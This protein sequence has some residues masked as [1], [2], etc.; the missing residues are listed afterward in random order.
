MFSVKNI[1]PITHIEHRHAEERQA[2]F[3]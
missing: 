1:N 3:E 2:E